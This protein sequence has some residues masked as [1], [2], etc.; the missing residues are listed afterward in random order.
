MEAGE[1]E[2]REFEED[3]RRNGLHA[4]NR[5]D[6]FVERFGLHGC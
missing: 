3:L 1:A 2:P 4:C 5:V 6:L